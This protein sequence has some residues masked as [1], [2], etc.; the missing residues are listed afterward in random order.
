MR[1]KNTF[2]T[3]DENNKKEAAFG[4]VHGEK[5]RF[6]RRCHMLL[7]SNRGKTVNEIASLLEVSRQTVHLCFRLY[8]NGGIDSL[9]RKKGGGRPPIIKVENQ[10]EI[11]RIK[12][13][14]EN[15]PQQVKAAI[16]VIEKEFGFSPTV[17]TLKRFLKKTISA[18]NASDQ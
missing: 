18:T 7:L 16:P 8:Q 12:E 10:A 1:G 11:D 3:L 6:R 15:H 5:S 2:V 4:H 14:V 9:R 17:V 13:I